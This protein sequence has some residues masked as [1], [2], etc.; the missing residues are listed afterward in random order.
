MCVRNCMRKR[1]LKRITHI[2]RREE[3]EKGLKIN[4][5]D[6]EKN[7]YLCKSLRESVIFRY[8]TMYIVYTQI[9]NT[10][11]VNTVQC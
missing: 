10:Y 2:F 11:I 8:S 6:G 4:F 5:V 9:V 3:R 7:Q 1:G